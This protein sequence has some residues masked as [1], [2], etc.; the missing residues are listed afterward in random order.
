MNCTMY[1]NFAQTVRRDGIE[2]AAERAKELGFS[3]VEFF[4]FI[5][6]TWEPVVKDRESAKQMKRVLDYYGLKVA[7]YSVATT[8]YVDGMTPDTVTDAE[9]GL[10]HYAEL[11]QELASPFLH[12][13]LIMDHIQDRLPFDEALRLI[14]PTAVRVAKH[15]HALGVRCIYEDQGRFFNGVQKFGEFFRAVKAECPYVGVCGD[16]GNILFVD[17]SPVEFFKTYINDILHVHVKDYTPTELTESSPDW[18]ISPKGAV[19][20]ECAIG[21]GCIDLCSCFEILKDAGYKGAFGFENGPIEEY[22][23]G[24]KNGQALLAE[25]FSD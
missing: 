21:T 12:H 18:S 3:S 22:E 15:A 23:I 24:V 19:Y 20:A 2:R 10:Y 7:C 25:Y 6:P 1:T 11:A 16:T 13:T 9:R 8:L 4:E 5:A 14:V 17:E